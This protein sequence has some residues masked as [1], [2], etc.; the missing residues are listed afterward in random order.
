MTWTWIVPYLSVSLTMRYSARL[1]CPTL[2]KDVAECCRNCQ[3][4]QKVRGKKMRCAPLI[5]LPIVGEA[6][7]RIAIDIV[8]PL[9]C[10][11]AG[12]QYVLVVC[13]YVKRYP[14]QFHYVQ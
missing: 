13:D 5:P 8:G 2:Y 9:P 11:R 14:M 6:F 1:Y 7:Q 12:N 4:C 10:S 3:E